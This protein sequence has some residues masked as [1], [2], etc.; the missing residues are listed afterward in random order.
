MLIADKGGLLAVHWQ[1]QKPQRAGS[2]L[3][4]IE[5][6]GAPP[7]LMN[8]Y[9]GGGISGFP[10]VEAPKLPGPTLSRMDNT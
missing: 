9:P 8:S 6:R 10:S 5:M 2:W 4:Q 1:L 3:V 7:G